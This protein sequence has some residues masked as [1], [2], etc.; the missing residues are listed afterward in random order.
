MSNLPIIEA[1]K[2]ELTSIF[3]DLH[4]H[5]EIGFNEHRTAGV[6][7]EKLK[8]YGVD[9][10]HTGIA[11]TGVVGIIKGN[12]GSRRVGLRADM[13]A[14]PID[15][16]TNLNYSSKTPGIMHACG[17]DGHTAM[18]LGAAKLLS[19]K[20]DFN[21][22]VYFI[23]QPAE[24]GGGGGLAMIDDCGE[25]LQAVVYDFVTHVV[26]GP[27]LTADVELGPTEMLVVPND[28]SN[29]S[30]NASCQDTPGCIDPTANNFNWM[31]TVDDGS[32]T[33]DVVVDVLGCMDATA[34]NFNADA[35]VD[36]GSCTYDVVELTNA[37]SLQGVMDFTVPSGGSD[38]KAIHLVATADIADLSVYGIGV[39]NN[40]GG[41]DGME[42]TLDS[43]S[44][45]AGDDILIAR[46]VEA[47]QAYFADCFTEFEIV[48]V[49]N[50]DIS[51]NGDDAIELYSDSLV[52]ETFGDVDSDGT[53][54]PWEYMDSWAYKV[55]GEWIYGTVNCT[56]GTTTSAE[57]DCPYPMCNY[58][59]V[60]CD[61]PADWSVI[62]TGSNH[63]IVIPSE[64]IV[65]LA[66]GNV[67]DHANVGV[68]YT[69]SC[70]LY[71]SP[72]PRDS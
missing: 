13:D 49:A 20:N 11:G 62:V 19:L 36:D 23:F 21:G 6:V 25:C 72:S 44:A 52:I 71:T 58:A 67:L 43:L 22:T 30:W 41:T 53:G 28:P 45:V 37:L 61:A 40:G 15:E 65:T 35:T 69:N 18:L 55:A 7:A 63:T 46:S 31:A 54:Q 68:F 56:D 51:Q 24:E 33:Y 29:P 12:E 38:G 10:V 60:G 2:D 70:L 27:A 39:A 50:S 3:K 4:R 9:E 16:L 5:P 57:S 66:D 17:H 64:S 34:N 14:L 26:T 48:M 1:A 42:Y 47:M 59:P 8:E 32:C